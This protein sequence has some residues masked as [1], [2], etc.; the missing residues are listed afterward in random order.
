MPV[1]SRIFDVA[2]AIVASA[3]NGSKIGALVC[4]GSAPSVE[5]GY[6]DAYCS[7]STTWRRGIKRQL[8]CHV[9]DKPIL[10]ND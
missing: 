4:A 3:M 6:F 7:S 8:E 9:G 5:Y 1:A 10:L 2:A